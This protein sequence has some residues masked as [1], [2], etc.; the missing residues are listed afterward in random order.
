VGL[1]TLVIAGL[2]Y[3]LRT[4]ASFREQCEGNIVSLVVI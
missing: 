3:L 4:F 2:L 1:C